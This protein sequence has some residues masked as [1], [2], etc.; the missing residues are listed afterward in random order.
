MTNKYRAL[1]FDIIIFVLGTV[2]A[3]A[4]QFLLMPMYTYYMSVESY[5]IAELT[6]NFSE[7]F[8][9]I[10]TLCIYE[11]AFRFAV[12]TSFNKK[13]LASVITKVMSISFLIGFVITIVLRYYFYYKYAFFL[14]FVLYTYSIRMCIAYYVRGLGLSKIFV[15]SGIINAFFLA[16]FSFIFIVWLKIDVEGY[17]GAIGLSNL[18]SAIYLIKK[19]NFYKQITINVDC[20]E[21]LSKIF[22]YCT[23][24]IIYNILYWF[25]MMSGRFIL[26]IYTDSSIAG[27]YLA[28]LKI[29]AVVNMIQQSIYSALQLH[30]SKCYDAD[31]KDSFYSEVINNFICFYCLFGAIVICLSPILAEF[32]L[33]KEFYEARIYLPI[34]ILAALL[35]CISS[36]IGVMYSAS[37]KTKRVVR[38]SLLGASIN[39]IFGLILTPFF[40]IW[41]VCIASIFCFLGQ[42]VYKLFDIRS[43][44]CIKYSW[45]R[46]IIN[47]LVI[48]TQVVIISFQLPDCYQ[49]AIALTILLFII[50]I[51]SFINFFKLLF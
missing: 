30:S 25:T 11:S 7:L 48:T 32:T 45:I 12:S 16:I 8:F 19:G 5:G 49:I 33:K 34:V 1:F 18:L 27:K 43:F 50:D 26:L 39:V 22:S 21:E 31:V 28:V 14:F 15:I 42:S 41:G 9:P 47:T 37:K 44:C 40:Y 17:L 36:V 13:I 46:I 10:V 20:K 51:R 4:I 29:S 6:N 23:P 2:F 38:V 35:N 3:K 24:L